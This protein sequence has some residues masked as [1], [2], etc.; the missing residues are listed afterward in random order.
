MD[1]RLDNLGILFGLFALAIPVLLHLL[2]RRRYDILDWAAMQFLPDSI[3]TQR[4]RWLDELLLLLMRMGIIALLVLAL[5]TPFSTSAWLAPLGDHATRDV[6]LVLDGSYSMDLRLPD[7]PTPWA[8]ALRWVRAHLDQAYRGDRFALL[9]AQQTPTPGPTDFCADHDEVRAKL[10][11][12]PTPRGNPDMPRALADAWKLLQTRGKASVKEIIVLTD[13]Q[14]FGWA[15]L[16]TLASLDNLGNP[17]RA[18]M[19]QAKNAGAAIPSLRIVKLGAPLPASL[20]NYALAP[21]TASRGVA[22]VGQKITFQSALHLDGFDRY[23]PPRQMKVMIDGQTVQ[24]VPL[25]EKTELKQGQIPLSFQ[26]RFDKE[27]THTVALVVEA[28]D[29]LPGDNEQQTAIEIVKELPIVLVDGAKQLSPASSS[30]FLQR[31]LG[32]KEAVPYAAFTLPS[33]QPAVLVLADVPRLDSVQIDAVDGF[34]AEGGGLLIAV[35]PRVVQEKA[36]YNEQLYRNGQGW[37]PTKLLDV[38]VAR[39]S[40]QLEPRTFQH[41]ALELFRTAP[42]GSMSQARFTHWWKTKVNSKNHATAV[43]MLTN[44]DPLFIEKAYKQGRVILCTVPLDRGWD[45]TLP[46]TWEYPILMNELAFY[47]AGSRRVANAPPADL[48][49]SNLARCTDGDWRKVRESLPIPWQ[50]EPTSSIVPTDVQRQDLWWLL[51]LGVVG[52][53]CMEVWMTRRMALTRGR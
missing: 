31:A 47:L 33:P 27:G 4:R 15:D 9:V 45:S 50:L 19:E 28:E 25:P 20:P 49:E 34:L 21:L 53:L 2:Q 17:W 8:D 48:R 43:A 18:D 13:Q 42:D 32:T 44:G 3:S 11:A 26:H 36:F 5:A 37:L 6:V 39:E 29:S 23:V 10:V 41:P 24:K 22:K 52:F 16:A 30:F 46:N 51:L 7:Q 14:Q 35:G 38:G 40:R 1:F 12:L